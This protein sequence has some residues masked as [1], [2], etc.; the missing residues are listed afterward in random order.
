MVWVQPE[1]GGVAEELPSNVA[2]LSIWGVKGC[3]VP[4]EILSTSPGSCVGWLCRWSSTLVGP[5]E[6]STSSWV[7]LG[8]DKGPPG[9]EKVGSEVTLALGPEVQDSQHSRW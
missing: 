8:A 6:D 4:E 2:G 1:G 9:V 5:F 7:A 3:R